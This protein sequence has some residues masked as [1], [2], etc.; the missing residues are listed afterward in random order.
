VVAGPTMQAPIPVSGPVGATAVV[1]SRFG[2]AVAPGFG[3]PV[4]AG[5]GFGGPGFG[6]A[7]RTAY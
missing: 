1:P 5:Q 3:G 7:F 2:G 6:T 4:V